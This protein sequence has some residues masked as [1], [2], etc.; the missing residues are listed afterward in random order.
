LKEFTRHD[1][2][3]IIDDNGMDVEFKTQYFEDK[4]FNSN[5]SVIIEDLYGAEE[6]AYNLYTYVI[7][8]IDEDEVDKYYKEQYPFDYKLDYMSDFICSD[9][10]IQKSII[11]KDP[12]TSEVLANIMEADSIGKEYTFQ[13]M[14]LETMNKKDDADEHSVYSTALALL[15]ENFGLDPK[16][17][18]EFD[19]YINVEKYNL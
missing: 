10:D 11:E 1:L 3:D 9:K 7:D 5:V 4:Y 12:N 2:I 6:L 13:K 15:D 14:Y 19:I 17:K 8:F 16:T 18:K